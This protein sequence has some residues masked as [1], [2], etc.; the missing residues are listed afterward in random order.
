MLYL[1]IISFF[2]TFKLTKT[3]TEGK[4]IYKIG[5]ESWN[6]HSLRNL[7]EEILPKN[8]E[9]KDYEFEHT[10]PDVGHKKMVLNARR[11]YREDIKIELILLAMEEV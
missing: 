7:L 3:K 1:R 8:N 9:M 4:K 5:Q 2:K 10:F 6:I 11:I